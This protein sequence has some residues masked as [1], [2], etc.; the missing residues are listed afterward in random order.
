MDHHIKVFVFFAIIVLIISCNGGGNSQVYKDLDQNGELFYRMDTLKIKIDD[1]TS[2]TYHRFNTFKDQD[3]FYLVRY[4][5]ST[6]SLLFFDLDKE[7]LTKT[8]KMDRGGPNAIGDVQNFYIHNLDSIFIFD[9]GNLKIMND[10]AE[11]YYGLNIYASAPQDWLVSFANAEAKPFYHAGLKRLI[12]KKSLRRGASQAEREEPFLITLDL[13]TKVFESIGPL[14]ADFMR[15][16]DVGFGPYHGVN[17]TNTD[18][19]V[20]YNYAVSSSVYSYNLFTDE[21]LGFDGDVNSISNQAPEFKNA[22]T[23]AFISSYRFETPIFY[24]LLYDPYRQLYYRLHR[25]AK[26][27][28]PG[29]TNTLMNTIFYVSVFNREMRFL[30]EFELGKNIYSQFTAFVTPKG[31]ALNASFKAFPLIEEENM[32]FHVFDFSFE[33]GVE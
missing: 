29:M 11:V 15:N 16:A 32:I 20:L 22:P 33:P 12:L 4:Q 7:K 18:S 3:D 17:F 9:L 27:Y 8:I 5:G 28:E 23:Q 26:N 1:K 2:Y 13:E 24:N 14:H 30:E 21:H 19:L 10:E 25:T 31:L 6:H